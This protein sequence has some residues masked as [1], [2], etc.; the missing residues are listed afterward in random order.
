MNVSHSFQVSFDAIIFVITVGE[1]LSGSALK[2][3]AKVHC[4]QPRR[5]AHIG[6]VWQ[7]SPSIACFPRI[8]ASTFSLFA[9]NSRTLATARG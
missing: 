6:P 3:A 7:L 9:R 4:G 2:A 8:T 1:A 5:A